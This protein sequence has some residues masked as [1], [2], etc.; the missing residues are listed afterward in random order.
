MSNGAGDG[1]WNPWPTWPAQP[2]QPQVPIGTTWTVP[3]GCVCPPTSEQTCQNPT[4]PR[5]NHLSA[6]GSR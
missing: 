4:C 2:Y 3:Q 5:K 6:G 1:P